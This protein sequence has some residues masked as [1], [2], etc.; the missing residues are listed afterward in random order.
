MR[1]KLEFLATCAVLAAASLF[2]SCHTAPP[3]PHLLDTSE[4]PAPR[5]IPTGFVY[6]EVD[7]RTLEIPRA[8]W[9]FNPAA[10]PPPIDPPTGR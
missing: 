5:P 6:V 4:P 7:G 9:E 2:F 8:V 3:A 1:K 10:Y